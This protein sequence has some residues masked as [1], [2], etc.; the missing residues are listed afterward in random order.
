MSRFIAEQEKV[1]SYLL[2][3]HVQPGNWIT[4]DT[5]RLL[6]AGLAARSNGTAGAAGRAVGAIAGDVRGQAYTLAFIDAFQLIAWVCVATLLLLAT[7]RRFPMNFRDL[8]AL[9]TG[10]RH[11]PTG[12][13]S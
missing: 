7:L 1:H 5:V 3:L 13:Q 9:D 2:G 10:A 4:E 8:A 12:D 6:S 11:A